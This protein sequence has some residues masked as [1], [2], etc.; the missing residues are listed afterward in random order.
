MYFHRNSL[1]DTLVNSN[2]LYNV[3]QLIKAECP[4]PS[5]HTH[6]W[7]YYVLLH[8][9]PALYVVLFSLKFHI[10]IPNSF[11]NIAPAMSGM[12]ILFNN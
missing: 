1:F 9:S 7:L 3:L 2:N 10:K 6:L 11:A 4:P 8:I 5:L 12:C